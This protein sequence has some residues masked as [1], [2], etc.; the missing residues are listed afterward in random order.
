[1]KNL[2]STALFVP[3]DKLGI[4]CRMKHS[5]HDTKLL[6]LANMLYSASKSDR[7]TRKSHNKREPGSSC[8]LHVKQDTSQVE[9]DLLPLPKSLLSL[10]IP[11]RPRIERVSNSA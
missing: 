4:I 6:Y 1:M 11:A 2:C 3:S 5:I 9:A 7:V 10:P 8:Q